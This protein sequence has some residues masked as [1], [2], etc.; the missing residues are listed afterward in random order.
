MKASIINYHCNDQQGM[1]D[2]SNEDWP[3]IISPTRVGDH[4]KM[5]IKFDTKQSRKEIDI[6]NISADDLKSIQRNDPFLYYSI[7][8]VRSAKLL[9]KDIDGTNIGVSELTRSH[10]SCP[11]RLENG[12]FSMSNQSKKVTRSTCISFECHPD[13]ILEDDF[14]LEGDGDIMDLDGM[15]DPLDV[16]MASFTAKQ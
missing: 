16:F 4:L 13:M 5:K 15:M 7:P 10:V 3:E 14:P 2:V 8:G 11:S 9:M 1:A 6:K 12:V